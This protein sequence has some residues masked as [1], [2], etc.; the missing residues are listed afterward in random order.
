MSKPD[1]CPQE[2]WDEA[3]KP[4][5]RIAIDYEAGQ[6]WDVRPTIARAILAAEKRGEERE[7]EACAQVASGGYS[8]KATSPFGQGRVAASA[9]IRARIT[10]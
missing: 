9:A 6:L 7:R 10:P 3:E 2:V 5:L 8:D 4:E 1:W